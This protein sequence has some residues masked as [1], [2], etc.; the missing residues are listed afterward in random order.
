MNRLKLEKRKAVVMSLVEGNSINATVR[1]TGVSKPTILK[2]LADLGAA[3]ATYHDQNVRGLKPDSVQCD[4]VWS[5]VYCKQKRVSSAKTPVEGAGDAWTWTALDSD[6]KLI[7][8][9]HVGL[10]TRDDAHRFM[11]DLSGR[12]IN[13]GQITTDGFMGYPSAV[14]EAFGAHQDYAQVIKQYA[15]LNDS[16]ERKYSPAVCAGCKIDA[17]SGSP[18]PAR[19][20][21][22]HVERH[23]L[24]IRMQNRRFTRLTN[25][26]SKKID[27]HFYALA[28]FFMYYNYCRKHQTLNGD[29]PA[30][31]AALADHVWTV[32]ELIGLLD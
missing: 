17:V 27:N 21:T 23:N 24:T 3:C 4:E 12:V 18:D 5:F 1:M 8:S 22:S 31:A 14:R 2:L 28:M 7:I 10:R 25:A 13:V 15:E 26:H 32:E 11:D 6:S 30:M 9:Y 20:S 19:A 16:P 29:T